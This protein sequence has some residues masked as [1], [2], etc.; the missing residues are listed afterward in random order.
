MSL[1][2][3]VLPDAAAM[4]RRGAELIGN[5][6]SRGRLHVLGVATGSSPSPVYAALSALRLPGWPGIQV[7]ALDEYA[8]L[9][10]DHPQSYHAVIDREVRRPLGL[11]PGDVHVP[12][13]SASDLAEACVDYEHSLTG[14]GG[15][16]LQILGIGATGHIGFN[17]PGSD[18]TSGT[19]VV[20]LSEKTRADNARFFPSAADVPH[21][22]LTQ[23]IGTIS[24]ARRHL[25]LA[26]GERKAA[27]VHAALQGPVSPDCPASALRELPDV[28]VLLDPAAAA[29]LTGSGRGAPGSHRDRFG[30]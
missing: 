4:G 23:G 22:A 25:L 10:P 3:E 16:D 11:A 18:F 13:G 28:T 2:V 19:R 21:R 15:V 7:F 8:G 1:H 6:L 24:R 26:R 29:Q 30:P 14:H 17:E 9:P 27:A 12:D 20:Q 5:H